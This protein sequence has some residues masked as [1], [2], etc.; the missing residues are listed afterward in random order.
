MRLG[1]G[2]FIPDGVGGLSGCF[3][4][5]VSEIKC[6]F[7]KQRI[8]SGAHFSLARRWST[9]VFILVFYWFICLEIK[10]KK[11]TFFFFLP[12]TVV[13]PSLLKKMREIKNS[14]KCRK[15]DWEWG[16]AREKNITWLCR[17]FQ[18]EAKSRIDSVPQEN[19]ITV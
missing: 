19:L 14:A 4:D 6:F 15:N 10:G 11:K 1:E 12:V 9:S 13:F 8:F 18:Q 2:C 17:P 3:S 16:E 7:L 5:L